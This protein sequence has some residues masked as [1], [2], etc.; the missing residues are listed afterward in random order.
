LS[1][2]GSRE[3]TAALPFREEEIIGAHPFAWWLASA[4]LL[5][6]GIGLGAVW[7]R[8]R[9]LRDVPGRDALRAV[10]AADTWWAVAA[11]VWIATGL[12]RLL[13]GTEKPTAYYLQNHFFWTK[14]ALLVLVLAL[15]VS[16]MVGL[17][18]WRRVVARGDVPDTSKAARY[19]VTSDL[20]AW[21]V[22]LMVLA[23][24]GMARGFG[25]PR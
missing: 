18:G 21:L 16:P 9:A 10:F 15:E 13:L 25:M 14:L 6:L 22:V 24:T 19:A 17:I 8:A 23:A 4:H 2:A 12:A 5:G 1:V 11:G 3:Q 20:Q 7:A